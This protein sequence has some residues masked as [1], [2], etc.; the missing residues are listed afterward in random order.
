MASW[1]R[2]DVTMGVAVRFHDFEN[3]ADGMR[4]CRCSHDRRGK[5]R[6]KEQGDDSGQPCHWPLSHGSKSVPV[7]LT[8]AKDE[9][10]PLGAAWFA[11]EG[12]CSMAEGRSQ[13]R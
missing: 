5:Q 9:V 2:D 6:G 12:G 11:Q 13:G 10:R 4:M 1:I 8:R 7:W 3:G